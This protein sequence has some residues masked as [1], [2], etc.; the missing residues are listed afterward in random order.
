MPGEAEKTEWMINR[1]ELAR[2][3]GVSPRTVSRWVASGLLPPPMPGARRWS[4]HS[5]EKAIGHDPKE[6]PRSLKCRHQP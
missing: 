3:L 1:E 2:T 5:V 6:F 4:R